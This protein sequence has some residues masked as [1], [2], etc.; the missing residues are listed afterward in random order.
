[1]TTLVPWR[2]RVARARLVME[3]PGPRRR[4]ERDAVGM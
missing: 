2:A 4:Q 3:V 1:M